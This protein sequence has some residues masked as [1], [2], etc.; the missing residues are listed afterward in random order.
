MAWSTAVRSGPRESSKSLNPNGRNG[1]TA[2]SG[3]GSASRFGSSDFRSNH[4]SDSNLMGDPDFHRIRARPMTEGTLARLALARAMAAG[5]DVVPLMAKAG[6]TRWQVEE[7]EVLIPAQG[8]IRLVELIADALHDDLLGFH[9][10]S[11]LDLREMGLL[12]YVLNS[13]NLLGDAVR[14]AERYCTIV[15]EGIR[16]RIREGKELALAVEFVG[17]ER[18]LDRHQIEACVTSLVRICRQLTNRELLPCLIS[19]V[20]RREGGCPEMD[21][22]MGREVTFG[23]DADEVD[24]AGAARQLPVLGADPYL[25]RLL[26][27]HCEE[28]RSHR[29]SSTVRV[30]VET[31]IAPLLPHGKARAPEIAHRLGMSPRTLGRRLATEGLTFS[32]VLDKLRADLARRYVQEGGLSISKIAWLLGYSEGSAFTHAHKRWTG[33]TPKGARAP[34]KRSASLTASDR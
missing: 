29:A 7:K 13:S 8:Q 32:T 3:N 2:I 14:R 33:R 12:Y 26:V 15:N 22:F 9:L 25:N 27:R 10:A 24:F 28:T 31:A 21:A 1:T 4:H 11:G 5:I 34:E 23:A 18:V 17:I 20:H 30:E 19:F 6:V 16:L